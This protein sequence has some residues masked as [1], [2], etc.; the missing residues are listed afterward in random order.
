MRRLMT[1]TFMSF[2]LIMA[3]SG[4]AFAW[5]SN[6]PI[7]KKY[8]FKFNLK[9]EIFEYSQTAPSYEDAFHKAAQACYNHY[10]AGRSL[11]EERGLDII[12]VCANPRI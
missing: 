12:D 10:K 4:D 1:I 8:V 5:A 3:I 9:K 11:N 7:E 6:Q 2:A